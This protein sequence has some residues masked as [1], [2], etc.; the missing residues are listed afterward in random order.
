MIYFAWVDATDT[1]FL[2]AFERV[3]ESV[4]SF[5]VDHAE[6]DFASMVVEIVNPRTGLLSVARKRWAW[7]AYDDGTT[8]TPLF[9]GRLVGA[10]ENSAAEL[11]TLT[12]VAKPPQY[13]AAKEAVADGLRVLP[14]FDPVW[15]APA[16]RAD[17]DVALEA[18]TALYHIDRTS[19]AVT[20]SDIVAGEDGTVDIGGTF[21]RDSLAMRYTEIPA[22]RVVVNAS[23]TWKQE[24]VGSV[25]VSR[26]ISDAFGLAG[27]TLLN[28]VSSYTGEGLLRDWPTTG[29]KI[30]AGWTVGSLDIPRVD[31]VTVTP[32]GI[33]ANTDLYSRA[34]FPLYVIQPKML[35]DY[36]ASR[37]RA[38]NV[39]FTINGGLQELIA[40]DDDEDQIQIDFVSSAA[41]D[42]ID[43]VLPIGDLGRRSYFQTDRGA[44][45][46]RYMMLVARAR[47][48]AQARAVEVFA[49]IPF[50]T[51]IGLSCRKSA[52]LADA[53][54]PGGT[55][56][57]KVIAYN[58]GLSGDDGALQGSVT[59]G[60]TIGTGGTVSAAVGVPCYVA[61]GYA[62]T[63]WQAF[64]GGD[65]MLATGDLAFGNFGAVNVAD[66]GV[67]FDSY[68]AAQAVLSCVVLNGQTD[69]E[70]ILQSPMADAE[71]AIATLNTV[72]T[73]VQL[74]LQPLAGLSFATDYP[75]VMSALAIPKTIDLGAA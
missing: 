6:G 66:D 57:G 48:I 60:C 24:A 45:S 67:N 21:Y 30:G 38:E 23:M 2:E 7:L 22:R 70:S 62:E 26:K 68:N 28:R 5:S 4:F 35:C 41:A 16:R 54:I 9:F 50:Q 39:T 1:T 15:L 10:P 32:R 61:D 44:E 11:V 40:D 36:V 52:T 29:R 43:G 46:L 72:P 8:V 18:R 73:V 75:L 49:Q 14:W 19:L 51:A 55:A 42:A 69:Q 33:I 71:T 27:T 59:I 17:A 74:N 63:G 34:Y 20:V 25:D 56:T 13:I 47:L 37:D 58:F 65:E 3:D 12:F 53:R 64:S 31:G